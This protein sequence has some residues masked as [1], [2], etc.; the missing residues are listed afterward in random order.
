[1]SYKDGIPLLTTFDEDVDMDEDYF[2][3][4]RPRKCKRRNILLVAIVCLA[5]VL[6][7]GLAVSV[8]LG[9]TLKSS[10]SLST[11]D[12]HGVSSGGV[13]MSSGGVVMSSEDLV[14]SSEGMFTSPMPSPS[15]DLPSATDM[16]PSATDMPPSS[17]VMTMSLDLS[18]SA[19]VVV[20]SSA[21]ASSSSAVVSSSSAVAGSSSAMA[22]SS[23]VMPSP[24]TTMEM[25]PSLLMTTPMATPLSSVSISLSVTMTPSPTPIPPAAKDCSDNDTLC[26]SPKD[27]RRYNFT[28]LENGL[29]VVVI[30]DPDTD[31]A[32]A[33]LNVAA[34]AFNDP[35]DFLGLSH[36]CEHMLFLGT[37]KYPG[38]SEYSAFLSSNGGSDN[39]YTSTQETNYHFRVNADFLELPLDMLAHFFID[40]LLTES[41][42]QSELFA[43]NQEHEKNLHSDGWKL[44]Q[45]LKH[46]SNPEHPFSKFS[47]GNFDTLNKSGLYDELRRYYNSSYVANH[48]SGEV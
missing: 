25:L 6:L 37:K 11:D 35:D 15:S 41:S 1:M 23:S 31:L 28:V 39:A 34:G 33:S 38:E 29:R 40:P 3:S 2:V 16:P 8:S 5:A 20:A 19:H 14:M 36:F 7:V 27:A 13:V 44:W 12:G 9:V 21:V 46:V 45:L 32:G 24:S 10:S 17:V 42:V 48:V 22:S 4:S 43:V 30:S 26:P 47:T 18:S